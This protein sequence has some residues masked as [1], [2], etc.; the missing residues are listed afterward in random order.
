[1]LRSNFIDIKRL[2]IP[3]P[4]SS[5]V[6]PP[7]ASEAVIKNVGTNDMRFNFDGDF[8]THYWVLK[9]GEQTPLIKVSGGLKIQTDGIGGSQTIDVWT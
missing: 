2:E 1:M 5:F 8:T 3:D 6:I 9:S 7:D 4:V